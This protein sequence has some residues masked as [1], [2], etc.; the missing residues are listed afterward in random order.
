LT[1][2]DVGKMFTPLAT[3]R[4]VVITEMIFYNGFNLILDLA[5]AGFVYL[6]AHGVGY[7]K[8]LWKNKPPF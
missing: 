5:I 1:A 3:Q 6:W 2:Q 7:R 4:L 8:G